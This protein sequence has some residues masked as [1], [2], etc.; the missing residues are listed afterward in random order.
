MTPGAKPSKAEPPRVP[1]MHLLAGPNGAGKSSFVEQVLAPITSLP[2]INADVIA[3]RRWPDAQAEHAYNAS[4]EAAVI[5]SQLIAK[6]ESF[7]TETVFSHVSKLAL[8]REAR[9]AGYLVHLHVVVV[10]VELSVARVAMRVAAGGHAVPEAK[11]RERYKRLWRLVASA[12]EIADAAAIYDS[13]QGGF[14]EIARYFDGVRTELSPWP[15]WS[16]HEL[17]TQ[18]SP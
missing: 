7:I 5:R 4:T 1:V 13:S 11:V 10:P 6:R 17:R 16:P 18:G 2:F 8:L 12:I 15:A 3:A 14:R 9:D